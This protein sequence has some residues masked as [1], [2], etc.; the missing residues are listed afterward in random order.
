MSYVW[1]RGH[2][3][4]NTP[5]LL[6]DNPRAVPE[7]AE[8]LGRLALRDHLNIRRDLY[9]LDRFM[10]Y[11]EVVY[12]PGGGSVIGMETWSYIYEHARASRG[13]RPC[14]SRAETAP[15]APPAA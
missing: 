9:I 4:T 11:Q 8:C 12:V 1:R 13:P 6:E 2:I 3:Y 10:Y 14:H 7:Q 5:A 15:R